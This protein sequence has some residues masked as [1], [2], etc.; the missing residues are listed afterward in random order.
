M[1][2]PYVAESVPSLQEPKEPLQSQET[3]T[4]EDMEGQQSLHAL[5]RK[6]VFLQGTLAPHAP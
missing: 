1:F 6:C 4:K 3:L 5:F 2:E